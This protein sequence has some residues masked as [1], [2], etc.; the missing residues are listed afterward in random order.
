MRVISS[1]SLAPFTRPLITAQAGE[2]EE[3][4]EEEQRQEKQE[5]EREQKNEEN[6]QKKRKEGRRRGRHAV[7]PSRHT[8]SSTHCSIE[9]V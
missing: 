7:I 3:K 2:E 5:R 4:K 9:A 8:A 1:N 6:K